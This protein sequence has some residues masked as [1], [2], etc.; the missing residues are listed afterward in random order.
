MALS[1]TERIETALEKIY[2]VIADIG[3]QDVFYQTPSGVFKYSD[4]DL[5]EIALILLGRSDLEEG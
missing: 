2:D 1:E 3:S 4:D 5:R